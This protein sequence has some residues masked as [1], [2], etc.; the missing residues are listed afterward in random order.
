[1]KKT[2]AETAAT[3]PTSVAPGAD[4]G[5]RVHERRPV[6]A[7]DAVRLA[8]LGVSR[9]EIGQR[10]GVSASRVSFVLKQC[11]APA[12][13][14][15]RR[16]SPRVDA[17]RARVRELYRHHSIEE[18]ARHEG[19]AVKT[20]WADV[21]ELATQGV[22]EKRPPGYRRDF[23]AAAIEARDARAAARIEAGD[24][25]EEIA[26]DEGVA[27][28]TIWR[29]LKARGVR[30]RRPGRRPRY[31]VGDRRRR[32]TCERPGCEETFVVYPCDEH[33]RHYCTF[34][35]RTLD[36]WRTGR[37]SRA[38]L[39]SFGA[40]ARKSRLCRW[41]GSKPPAEGGRR[42]RPP[43]ALSD[44][45]CATI[46]KLHARGWGRRAIVAQLDELGMPASERAARNELE[47]LNREQAA[48]HRP[49]SLPLD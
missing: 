14:P 16:Q 38:L 4:G 25:L 19:V 18:I 17:R 26:R 39:A 34:R 28:T 9:T 43:A 3:A 29:A 1:M 49:L 41:A 13:R 24:S 2:A 37:V 12:G 5:E 31:L 27:A 35:C 36:L 10:V 15:G 30:F 48:T 33:R 40:R 44:E 11:G 8:E 20:I 32:K 22:L 23:D 7:A 45:Q 21:D 47:R 46:A 6:W 42:G